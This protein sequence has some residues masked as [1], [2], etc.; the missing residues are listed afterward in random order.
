MSGSQLVDCAVTSAASANFAGWTEHS[1]YYYPLAF[2][3]GFNGYAISLKKWRALSAAEQERLTQAFQA[4]SIKLWR[5][6]EALQQESERCII[7]GPCR[8]LRRHRLTPVEVKS[9]DIQLL[10]D[11]S[12]QAVLPSWSARCEQQHPGCRREWEQKVIPVV[13]FTSPTHR[14]P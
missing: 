11:L 8:L 5:Y 3:F 6:S 4:F 12:R 9:E 10:Q 14:H 13:Q 7:G 1:H 2:Q